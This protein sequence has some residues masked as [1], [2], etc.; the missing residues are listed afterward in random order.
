MSLLL[1]RP[2]SS[3]LHW[4]KIEMESREERETFR[5]TRL[6]STSFAGSKMRR[7]EKSTRE[8]HRKLYFKVA[9]AIPISMLLFT[10]FL[11]LNGTVE[12]QRGSQARSNNEL[13]LNVKDSR[14]QNETSQ[15]ISR[16]RFLKE[17]SSWKKEVLNENTM[18]G[19]FRA[20]V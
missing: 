12:G 17:E 10:S 4:T 5:T 20:R 18:S 19:K 11:I 1:M 2:D 3:D 9:R 16:E 6:Q 7:R 15:L 13:E 8:M 14:S